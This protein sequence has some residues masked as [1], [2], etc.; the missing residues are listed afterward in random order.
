MVKLRLPL[1]YT[2]PAV[3]PEQAAA[4]S[5]LDSPRAV[6]KASSVAGTSSRSLSPSES[7]RKKHTIHSL[8]RSPKSR[9]PA[10]LR[11]SEKRAQAHG[12]L[13]SE[14]REESQKPRLSLMVVCAVRQACDGGKTTAN[15][16]QLDRD[17]QNHQI[18]RGRQ[19][20]D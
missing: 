2:E 10:N 7:L 5:M 13:K 6:K 4:D 18:R 1:D 9:R 19:I 8:M 16:R 14:W 11:R 15:N 20:L 3:E 17:Q 12:S